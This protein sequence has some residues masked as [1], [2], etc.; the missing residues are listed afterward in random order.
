VS[1]RWTSSQL[2]VARE[3][4]FR[5]DH[6]GRLTSEYA[7]NGKDAQTC[8]ASVNGVLAA[9]RPHGL[10]RLRIILA[11]PW[12]QCF[13]LP[14][15]PL[16]QHNDWAA[17]CRSRLSGKAGANLLDGWRLAVDDAGWNRNRLAEAAPET[18]CKSVASTC[19]KTRLVA[20]WDSVVI[21]GIDQR[22]S[23]QHDR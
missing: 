16:A 19:R 7:A 20:H 18:F 1:R 8:A 11:A 9:P 22:A 2:L 13:V 17:Y 6:K 12:S 23:P 21:C 15:R 4:I 10:H 3:R 14:W 5:F